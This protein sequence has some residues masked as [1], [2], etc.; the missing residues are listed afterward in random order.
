MRCPTI[1]VDRQINNS[2][3]DNVKTVADDIA[4]VN[5][6]AAAIGDG[7]FDN[8]DTV[9]A[10][11]LKNNINALGPISSNITTVAGISS[12]VSTVA[13]NAS[14]VASVASNI[15]NI[16]AVNSNIAY[17]TTVATNIT[18][19]NNVATQVVPNITE[20]LQADD[21]AATA[22]TKAAEASTSASNA[23]TSATNSQLDRWRAEAQ[24]L[25]ADSYATE[26]EDV[27]V[28][29]YT[30]DGDGTFTATATNPAEYSAKH[31]R[32][33]AQ[34]IV[35]SDAMLKSDY[36]TD[37]DGIVD[38]SEK[39]T[40]VNK[41]GFI[42]SGFVLSV[43]N[44]D[45][46]LIRI[47]A[48]TCYIN[49]TVVTYAG[50]TYATSSLSA[51]SYG[52]IGI[53]SSGTIVGKNNS[54]FT[55]SEL[56]NTLEIGAF[57]KSTDTV[58]NI[59]DESKFKIDTF[60]KDHMV[61][62]KAFEGTRFNGSAGLISK[63][64]TNTDRL[65]IAGGSINTPDAQVA[66]ISADTGI[67]GILNYRS[68]GSYVL[69]SQD[70]IQVSDTQY[71]NGT[72]LVS[73]GVSKYTTHTV[74]RSSR[75][76][77][78]YF[79]YGTEEFNTEALAK[80]ATYNLG[81]FSANEHTS[82]VEPLALVIVQQGNGIQSILDIRND[83]AGTTSTILSNVTLQTSYG[84]STA[85]HIQ[86]STNDPIEVRNDTGNTSTKLQRWT[87]SSGTSIFEVNKTGISKNGS[88]IVSLPDMAGTM[89]IGTIA[90]FEGEL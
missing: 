64:T 15:A 83:T 28:K 33:K 68:S 55:E 76:G 38:N 36:D 9:I 58:V 79:I 27:P 41:H 85:P 7:T 73:L 13:T 20:I 5:T 11:P 54:F 22:T 63:N 49:G 65:D 26:D 45:T 35:G 46:D 81:T 67:S 29:I 21:N 52:V 48:G 74:A 88:N 39:L 2:A 80:Q 70:P 57:A 1:Q 42:S 23:A 66:N 89:A 53:N 25:T 31:W 24:K 6:V 72:N 77:T 44:T 75:T 59:I 71:D 86:L 32:N 30:S 60:I 40:D 87:D 51:G 10:Q 16:I 69:V 47:T 4:H 14:S 56:N 8:V 43:D 61:R 19:I 50:G 18:N 62:T 78:I 3:Y 84:V 17:I 37:G 12:N 34:T 90:D 82:E